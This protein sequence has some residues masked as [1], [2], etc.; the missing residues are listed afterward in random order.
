MPPEA[1]LQILGSEVRSKDVLEIGCGGGQCSVYLAQRGARMVALDLS[2]RQLAHARAH[3]RAR[4]VAVRFIES[5]AEDLS[6]L[7]DASFN[8]AL[9]SFALG[10]VEDIGRAFREAHRVLRPGGL[11]AF[12]W[13]SPPRAWRR[14]DEGLYDE[15]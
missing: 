11:F 13:G 2:S 6:M 4:G 12:S 3:A 7:E 1:D 14:P 9:S 10:F 5:S 15:P 8:V